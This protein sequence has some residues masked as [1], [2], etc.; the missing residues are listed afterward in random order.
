MLFTRNAQDPICNSLSDLKSH[1]PI[2]ACPRE[3]GGMVPPF[4]I[5]RIY[6]FT[7][8]TSLYRGWTVTFFL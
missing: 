5:W 7:T 4:S 1:T 6:S 8:S 2:N 3:N